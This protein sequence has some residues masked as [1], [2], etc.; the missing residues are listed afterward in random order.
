[1]LLNIWWVLFLFLSLCVC[2]FRSPIYHLSSAKHIHIRQRIHSTKFPRHMVMLIREKKRRDEMKRN[3]NEKREKHTNLLYISMIL[4]QE[5][6]KVCVINWYTL[7]NLKNIYI[8]CKMKQ[9]QINKCQICFFSL[10]LF[11]FLSLFIGFSLIKYW[12]FPLIF[13][14]YK[15]NNIVSSFLPFPSPSYQPYHHHHRHHHYPYHI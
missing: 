1:M 12:F 9:M 8:C 5:G 2:A 7:V 6:K 11:L 4:L 3:E 15:Y 10:H 14:S 13:S